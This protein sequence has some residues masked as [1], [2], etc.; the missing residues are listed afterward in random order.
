MSKHVLGSGFRRAT[1]GGEAGPGSRAV[2][3]VRV[4]IRPVEI[5]NGSHLQFE[6]FE[7]KKGFTRNVLPAESGPLIEELL[8]IGFAGIHLSTTT[9][10]IDIRTSQKGRVQ[11][12]RRRVESAGPTPLPSAQPGEGLA[13]TGRPS[14]PGT[15][16]HGHHDPGGSGPPDDAGEVYSDQ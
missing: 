3:W 9:E 8:E 6:Y 13:A 12:G 11:I 15:G 14:G 10:E 2:T 7:I 4:L 16:S 1:F 5:R